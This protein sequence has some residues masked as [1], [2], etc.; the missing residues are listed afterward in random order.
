[1]FIEP[2]KCTRL[3]S[4]RISGCW[5]YLSF[6]LF[7]QSLCIFHLFLLLYLFHIFPFSI[8]IPFLSSTLCFSHLL[9]LILICSHIFLH[10][11]ISF[12]LSP[13]FTSSPHPL[14]FLYIFS[15]FHPSLCLSSCF[16]FSFL[17]ST[18]HLFQH[19]STVSLPLSTSVNLSPTLSPLSISILLLIPQDCLLLKATS[20]ATMECLEDCLTM[21]QRQEL[22][23][24]QRSAE[25]LELSQ[26]MANIRYMWWSAVD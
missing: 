11:S 16:Y 6:L 23:Q 10:F 9:S 1:M 17:S 26:S 20:Q 7:C 3:N 15:S 24:G 2:V 14:L 5:F 22:T 25:Q 12:L 4:T 13:Y 21:L 18:L 8:S 19:P